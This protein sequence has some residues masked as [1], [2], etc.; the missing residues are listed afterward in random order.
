MQLIYFCSE[1]AIDRTSHTLCYIPSDA[2]L[3]RRE[4]RANNAI[5]LF[6]QNISSDKKARFF[7]TLPPSTTFRKQRFGFRKVVLDGSILRR[8]NCQIENFFGTMR[9]CRKNQQAIF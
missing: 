4:A 7:G 6:R 5:H 3:S 1:G 9:S 2:F 8:P